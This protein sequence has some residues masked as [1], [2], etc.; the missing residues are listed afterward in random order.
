MSTD[1]V[2]VDTN[3]F[4]YVDDASA[5]TKR[6]K[7]RAA[8]APLIRS[9]R[10]VISTQVMQEYF[11]VATKKLR[12]SPERARWRVEALGRLDVVVVRPELILGAI[13]LHRLHSLS[14]WDALVL[15]CAS[16]GGCSRVLTED[17]SHG[18]TIDGV[19]IENPF[20]A[21][22]SAEPAVR[23]RTRPRRSA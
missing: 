10:A 16:A 18:Q 17:L 5:G 8:L 2:F 20:L 9:R 21:A 7:A 3:V 13:D 11:A 1:R 23:Y 19:R 12:M 4:V 22:R 14:L 6:D 15:R